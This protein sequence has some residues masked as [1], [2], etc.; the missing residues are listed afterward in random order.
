MKGHTHRHTPYMLL[1]KTF[2]LLYVYYYYILL[3]I[4]LV[5][6]HDWGMYYNYLVNKLIELKYSI[7]IKIYSGHRRYTY[8]VL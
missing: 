7:G 4:H 2:T 5:I 1:L 3:L 6:E 8:T